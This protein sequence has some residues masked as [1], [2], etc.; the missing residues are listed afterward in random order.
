M[1]NENIHPNNSTVMT[2]IHKIHI[3]E[4]QRLKEGVVYL[5]GQGNIHNENIYPKYNLKKESIYDLHLPERQR[6]K[7]GICFNGQ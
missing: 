4:R 3:P 7:E 5:K 1:H 6:L 2:R